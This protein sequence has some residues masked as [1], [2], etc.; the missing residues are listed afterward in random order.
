MANRSKPILISTP[1]STR[2][3]NLPQARLPVGLLRVTKGRA[4]MGGLRGGLEYTLI[5]TPRWDRI[6]LRRE[7]EI[8]PGFE[9]RVEHRAC[10]FPCKIYNRASIVSSTPG[11]RLDSPSSHAIR[12]EPHMRLNRHSPSGF[13]NPRSCQVMILERSIAARHGTAIAFE[14]R[15]I[16]MP[17]WMAGMTTRLAGAFGGAC[18]GSGGPP[19]AT[20]LSYSP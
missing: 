18:D 11:A 5:I 4:G 8:R 13:V 12:A 1:S 7:S 16:S 14:G 15:R 19:C 9:A 3:R 17:G 10:Q 2:E 20:P 6:C